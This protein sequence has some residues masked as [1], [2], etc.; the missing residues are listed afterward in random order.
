MKRFIYILTLILL[1]YAAT[2]QP[3]N[4][5]TVDIKTPL[6]ATLSFSE[7][8]VDFEPTLTLIEAA[9]PGGINYIQQ[10]KKELE[11][12]RTFNNRTK[13]YGKNSP[14]LPE[15]LRNFNGNVTQGTPNDNDMAINNNR[16]IISVVNTNMNVYND[17]GTYL[18]GKT[19]SFFANKLGSLNR[20]YDPRVIYDPKQDR[21]I[22]VFLQGT[23]S[24]DTRIVVAFSQTNDPLLNWNFYVVPGNVF[25]DSS[26]SDYPI[27]ALS[28]D[29]LFITVNRLRDNSGWK[30]GFIESLIWQVDK[31]KGYDGDT[32]VQ[33]VYKDIRYNGKAIWSVCPAK[34]G[35]TTYGPNMYFLSVRPSDLSNDTIFLHEITNTIA[36]GN[37]T[38]NTRI[39]KLPQAYG[40]Q[41]NAAMPNGKKLQTNDA[42]VLSAMYQEER[43]H[44]VGNSVD[45]S[46]FAPGIFYG[47][48]RKPELTNPIIN[49]RIISYD[50]MDIGY[51]SIAHMGGG[52]TD[53]SA[54]ITFSFSSP[55]SFPGTA[56]VFVDRNEQIS[57]PIVVKR[58]LSN[59]QLLSDSVQR[60]GDYTGNQRQY[61]KP[62]TCWISGSY[63]N[64]F[65]GNST[66]IAEIRTTDPLL[67]TGEVQS[68]KP[69]ISISPN[70]AREYASVE[71]EL[72]QKTIIEV[73]LQDISGRLSQQL[74]RAPAKAGINRFTFSVSDLS[75]GI[76]YI[77]IY[78]NGQKIESRKIV[79]AH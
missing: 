39:L 53:H 65:G 56:A 34:G 13:S 70:P 78:N 48:I 16:R 26:W 32:L 45:T 47:Y 77:T 27:I 71:F 76:Y 15:L 52:V 46:T 62:G 9:K 64:Q 12:K 40:L 2:A 73:E 59:I 67:S 33:K 36:S 79:V 43:I 25:G 50:T 4:Y 68:N 10:R 41:P 58:G 24:A 8:G 29:E 17:S 37:A 57:S 75:N 7:K 22:L 31:Q 42:R 63:G 28:N 1:E 60:W 38:L 49:Y 74:L 51:P 6:A 55:R 14:Y 11:L 19:L 20:T 69:V 72:Q 30:D 5:S 44:F 18:M 21:F 35:E 54:L 66:W 3:F 61:N 23:T